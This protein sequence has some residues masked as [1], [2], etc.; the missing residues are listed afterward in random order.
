M[1]QFYI[2]LPPLLLDLGGEFAA[3]KETNCPRSFSKKGLSR[4]SIGIRRVLASK[5]V[6]PQGDD[7]RS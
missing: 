4:F 2:V 7:C 3:S 1:E 5:V 6:L